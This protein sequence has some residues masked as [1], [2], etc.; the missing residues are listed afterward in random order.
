MRKGNETSQS[1]FSESCLI[2]TPDFQAIA[3]EH[4]STGSMIS[5]NNPEDIQDFI[6][7]ET[8]SHTN[9]IGR[10]LDSHLRTII[11]K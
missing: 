8:K 9:L 11:T 7:N 1:L 2:R 3:G 5:T 4:G 6:W 10:V